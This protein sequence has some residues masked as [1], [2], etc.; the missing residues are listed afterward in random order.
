[1][2]IRDEKLSEHLTSL[3]KSDGYNAA[4]ETVE[5]WLEVLAELAKAGVDTYQIKLSVELAARSLKLKIG[6]IS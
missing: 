6:R 3:I 5:D 2:V 1:M 4:C